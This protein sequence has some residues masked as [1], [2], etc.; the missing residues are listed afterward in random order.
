MPSKSPSR[1]VLTSKLLA[2]ALHTNVWKIGFHD[3]HLIH[4]CKWLAFTLT[5]REYPLH[6]L[7][8][9]SNLSGLTVCII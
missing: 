2:Q 3:N 5:M 8:E 6:E 7:L 4:D 9:H 1:V